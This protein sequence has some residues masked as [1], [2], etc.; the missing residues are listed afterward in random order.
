M[1][2]EEFPLWFSELKTRHS[3]WGNVGS[4]PGLPNPNPNPKDLVLLQSAV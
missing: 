3:V 4:T 2:L 1:K